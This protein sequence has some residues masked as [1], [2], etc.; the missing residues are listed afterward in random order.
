MKNEA[1]EILRDLM[2]NA[3]WYAEDSGDYAMDEFPE[4]EMLEVIEIIRNDVAVSAQKSRWYA[5][6]EQLTDIP[7]GQ[8][9]DIYRV[10]ALIRQAV[11]AARAGS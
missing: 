7:D 6:C 1:V 4:S 11:A 2:S 5:L 10:T 3:Y 9:H 8:L